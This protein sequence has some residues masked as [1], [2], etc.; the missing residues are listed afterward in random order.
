MRI[1]G[2]PLAWG[3]AISRPTQILAV[4]LLILLLVGCGEDEE[5]VLARQSPPPPEPAPHKVVQKVMSVSLLGIEQGNGPEATVDASDGT[6]V[7]VSLQDPGGSPEYGFDPAEL[8]FKVGETVSFTLTSETEFHTFTVED[9]LI[10]QSVDSG[11]TLSFGFIFTQAGE[12]RLICIPH[13]AQGMVGT[14]VVTP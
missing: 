4:A 14:I 11:E 9:L 8:S 5:I 3:A 2:H 1:A 6:P 7:A 13:E 10:D 12:Y